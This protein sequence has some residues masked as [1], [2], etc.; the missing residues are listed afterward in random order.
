MLLC[1]GQANQWPCVFS[2]SPSG[3]V[4]LISVALN[5]MRAFRRNGQPQSPQKTDNG[6]METYDMICF[7]FLSSCPW[8][9]Q[10]RTTGEA[11]RKWLKDSLQ[12]SI[13][14]KRLSPN[15]EEPPL[16][17]LLAIIIINDYIVSI[18]SL[19]PIYHLLSSRNAPER[20]HQL[21]SP[22]M[23]KRRSRFCN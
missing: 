10:S 16:W 15:N 6:I 5:N 1:V 17:S 20:G 3:A 11:P 22:G 8:T 2:N 19:L 21:H 14:N 7:H 4:G 23:D 12:K 13:S 18:P 9:E